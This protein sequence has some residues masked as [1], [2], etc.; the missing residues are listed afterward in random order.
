MVL[1][2]LEDRREEASADAA[3]IERLMSQGNVEPN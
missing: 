2:D 1:A 3:L